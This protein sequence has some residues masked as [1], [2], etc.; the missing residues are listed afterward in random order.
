MARMPQSGC[1][2]ANGSGM[3]EAKAFG[4]AVISSYADA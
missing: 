2:D 4:A 1:N 3:G